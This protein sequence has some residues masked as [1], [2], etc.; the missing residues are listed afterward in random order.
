[1]ISTDYL[2]KRT[3][4]TWRQIDYWTRQGYLRPDDEWAR[5]TGNARVYPDEE[6]RVA[7]RMRDLTGVGFTPKHA[8]RLARGD[9][10]LMEKIEMTLS[11]VRVGTSQSTHS[12]AER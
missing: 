6:M 7:L 1:M 8:A 12:S 11:A 3:G 5:G 9:S 10:A 2:V 4:L